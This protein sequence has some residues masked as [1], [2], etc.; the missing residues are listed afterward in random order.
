MTITENILLFA[1]YKKQFSRKEL[2]EYF[3]R[4][5]ISVLPKSVSE[6]I[7]RMLKSNRLNRVSRGVYCFPDSKNAFIPKVSDELQKLNEQLK[8]QF[9]FA[10]FCL[11]YSN[12][13]TPFMHHIPQLKTIFVEVER[14]ALKSIFNFLNKNYAERRVFLTPN[15]EEYARY[16]N[17]Q[18]AII[19]K[20]LVSESP[21][22]VIQNINMPAIEKILV[23]IIGDV[24]FEFLQGT[25]MDRFYR[26]VLEK[27]AV[28]KRK[29]MR[30]ASRR[31]RRKEVEQLYNTC[32]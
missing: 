5:D 21:V 18:E 27:L 16:I 26:N 10:S 22:Q 13:I 32:L 29:L 15:S 24:D 17:G 31:N 6:Q 2:L 28:N 19:V 23:D 7:G 11:W 4:Q 1:A 20:L 3:G 14:D 9:P 8:N 12:E 25:E 30:Y